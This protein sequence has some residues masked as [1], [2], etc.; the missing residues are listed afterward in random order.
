MLPARVLQVTG[1]VSY[2]VATEDGQ[3][4]RRHI[5]QLWSHLPPDPNGNREAEPSTNLLSQPMVSPPDVI[6]E[7]D[8]DPREGKSKQ[9]PDPEPHPQA[10]ATGATAAPSLVPAAVVTANEHQGAPENEAPHPELRCSQRKRR[11]AA[12]LKDCIR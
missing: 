5:N 7:E 9:P 10:E 6:H 12:N 11:P 2:E 4:L 8:H 1:L 3:T